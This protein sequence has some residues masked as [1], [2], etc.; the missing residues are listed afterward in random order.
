[1]RENTVQNN[2]EYGYFSRSDLFGTIY[3]NAVHLVKTYK[4]KKKNQHQKA[5][6]HCNSEIKKWRRLWNMHFNINFPNLISY[7]ANSSFWSSRFSNFSNQTHLMKVFTAH[8]LI[9]NKDAEKLF[10]SKE[11]HFV[12]SEVLPQKL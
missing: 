8:N 2:S 5:I 7:L 9:R 10:R 3:S 12:T 6:K 1:M 4:A 11:S